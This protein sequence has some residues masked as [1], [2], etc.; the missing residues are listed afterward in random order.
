M[1]PHLPNLLVYATTVE[2]RNAAPFYQPQ[3]SESPFQI[4]EKLNL[5]ADIARLATFFL[6]VTGF[7]DVAAASRLESKCVIA[8][9]DVPATEK[10]RERDRSRQSSLCCPQ[11]TIV[12]R[13]L[14]AVNRA[15]QHWQ[16]N[17][18]SSKLTG[19]HSS[20][21]HPLFC[22]A[23]CSFAVD[24]GTPC[25]GGLV[26]RAWFGFPFGHVSQVKPKNRGKHNPLCKEERTRG[27][28]ELG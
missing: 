21:A 12:H 24:A 23:A 20:A 1:G 5:N 13:Q 16:W 7:T 3:L 25:T 10:A 14:R 9:P 26:H 2:S 11:N 8:I 22:R 27:R 19:F 6:L 15:R 17:I 4:Q 18:S 28:G